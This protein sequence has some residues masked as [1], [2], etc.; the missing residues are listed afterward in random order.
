M[1]GVMDELQSAVIVPIAVPAAVERVRR[2]HVSVAAAGVPPHLTLLSP[3]VPAAALDHGVQARLARGLSA[4][5]AF[6]A[7]FEAVRRFSDALYL[8]PEPAA[9]F[10]DLIVAVC[11]LF[12][13]LPPYGEASYHPEDVV[14][15]LAIAIGDG[16]KFDDLEAE[17]ARSLPFAR[18]IDEVLVIAERPGGRWRTRWRFNLERDPLGRS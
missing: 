13:G 6:D 12:P 5:E 15:H 10:R 7:R 11:S 8:A 3:F 1:S 18:R 2:T 4:F 9:P 17:A 16:A 14:P